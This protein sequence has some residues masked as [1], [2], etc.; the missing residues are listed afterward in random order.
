MVCAQQ[1]ELTLF[2][3]YVFPVRKGQNVDDS[4]ENYYSKTI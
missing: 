2:G 4:L 1:F 3:K